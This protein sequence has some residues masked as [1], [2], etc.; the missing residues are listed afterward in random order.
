MPKKDGFKTRD[1]FILFREISSAIQKLNQH[2]KKSQKK[3]CLRENIIKKLRFYLIHFNINCRTSQSKNKR[4]N[5]A[6]FLKSCISFRKESAF[7]R[8]VHSGVLNKILN[9]FF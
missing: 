7:A 5:H 8:T 6:F 4:I 1:P 3:V 2:L 9:H